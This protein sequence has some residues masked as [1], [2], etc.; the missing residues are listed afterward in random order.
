[1]CKVEERVYL[2]KSL[3]QLEKDE[4]LKRQGYEVREAALITPGKG[5]YYVYIKAPC[6]FFEQVEALKDAERVEGEEEKRIIRVFKEEE[7]KAEEG[8]GAL[9]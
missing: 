3:K 5:G 1:M 6:E 4:K 8:L 9:F 7:E 2:V